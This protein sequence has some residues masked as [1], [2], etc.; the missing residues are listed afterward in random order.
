MT[1]SYD[2]VIIGAGIIGCAIAYEL[3]KGGR[4]VVCVDKKRDGRFGLHRQF[5]RNHPNPLFDLEW[6]GTGKVELSVLGELGRIPRR[7]SR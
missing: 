2:A 4:K 6:S 1:D 5:L 3:A 7:R